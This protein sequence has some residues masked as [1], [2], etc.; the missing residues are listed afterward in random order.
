MER[1]FSLL[2]SF[3]TVRFE[4]KLCGFLIFDHGPTLRL[5][6]LLC[7]SCYARADKQEFALLG[8]LLSTLSCYVLQDNL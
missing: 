4:F 8:T 7:Q 5:K 3:L 1:K 6:S 2:I